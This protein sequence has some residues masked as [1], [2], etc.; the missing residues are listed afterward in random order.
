MTQEVDVRELTE[1]ELKNIHEIYV[2]P[3]YQCNLKCPH[4]FI[5]LRKDNMNVENICETIGYLNEHC[6]GVSYTLFGGEPLLLSTN[7]LDQLVGA[8][9]KNEYSVSTNLLNY[10]KD[11]HF[12]LLNNGVLHDTSWNQTRFTPTQYNKWVKILNELSND[13]VK[14]ELMITLTKD[15][16]ETPVVDFFEMVKELKASHIKL[17]YMIGDDSIDFED[18]DRWLCEL[19]KMW[20]TQMVN[21]LF[22]KLKLISLGESKWEDHCKYT[23]TITPSGKIKRG[24]PYNEGKELTPLYNCLLCEYNSVCSG[25]CKLQTKC[26]FPKKLYELVKKDDI[27]TLEFI[28]NKCCISK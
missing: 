4:C 2:C 26:T 12:D 1:E 13:G 14:M 11:K 19:F 18:V 17:E 3:S 15:L 9:D 10:E 16:I 28:K 27:M 24:C 23:Y 22:Q 6:P 8:F 5:H 7:T 20:D 21:V 25:G